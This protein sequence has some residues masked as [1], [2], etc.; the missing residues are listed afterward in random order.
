MAMGYAPMPSEPGRTSYALNGGL[1]R[2]AQAIGGAVA[3][4]FATEA[5][6]ADTAGFAYS[7]HGNNAL[8]VGVAGEF[9]GR[10]GS[11]RPA[12]SAPAPPNSASA[13]LRVG[14]VRSTKRELIVVTPGSRPRCSRC[15][16]S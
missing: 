12:L 14:T 15:S 1:F 9:E 13:S 4:R 3:H 8:R 5:P 2:N 7:G 11:Y 10:R 16:R 6:L